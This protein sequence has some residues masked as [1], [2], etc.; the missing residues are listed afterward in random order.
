MHIDYDSIDDVDDV[1]E[2]SV[3]VHAFNTT[4]GRWAWTWVDRFTLAEFRPDL[5]NIG[6]PDDVEEAA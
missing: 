1:E 6:L 2:E 3:L 4:T 5:A